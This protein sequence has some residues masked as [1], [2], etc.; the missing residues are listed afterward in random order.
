MGLGLDARPS[1]GLLY[2]PRGC[3]HCGH[4]GFRGRAAILEFLEVN[5][6][7][8]RLIVDRAEAGDIQRAALAGSMRSMMSDGVQKAGEGVTTLDEVLRVTREA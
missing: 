4:T 5:D 8:R 2:A 7:I 3:E 1:S 6:D